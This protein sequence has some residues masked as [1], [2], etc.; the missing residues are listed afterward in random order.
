MDKK[1]LSDYIDA[2]ELVKETEQD[3]RRLKQK[4]HTIVQGNVKGSNPEFPYQEQHFRIAG[5]A[6]TY[7]DDTQVRMEEALLRERKA[8]AE[9]IKLEVE[10]WINTIPMRIQRIVRY[11]YI[12]GLS[13]ERTADRMGRKATG[14]G[15]RKELERFLHEK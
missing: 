4:K 1:I 10:A 13:W 11:R 15:I 8:R 12:K 2:C 3:I 7:S 6:Y 14:D 9:E 5:M